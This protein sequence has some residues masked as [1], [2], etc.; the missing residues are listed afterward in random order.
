MSKKKEGRSEEGGGGRR[1]GKKANGLARGPARLDGGARAG[2]GTAA[3]LEDAQK[4]T[5]ERRL[6]PPSAFSAVLFNILFFPPPFCR[7]HRRPRR[8]YFP[9]RAGLRRG[10]GRPR[11]ASSPRAGAVFSADAR[12]RD[13]RSRYRTAERASGPLFVPPPS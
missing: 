6:R 10:P 12:S 3:A 4:C 13:G 11:G 1:N 5:E 8:R 7:E 2:E 9:S